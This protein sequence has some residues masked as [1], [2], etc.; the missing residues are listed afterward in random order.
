[1]K[2]QKS[3]IAGF[4]MLILFGLPV[5][6]ISQQSAPEKW[7]L[8]DTRQSTKATTTLGLKAGLRVSNFSGSDAEGLDPRLTFALGGFL[9]YGTRL[10]AFQPEIWY[11]QNGASMDMG[12]YTA[13]I[14][15]SYLNIPLLFKFRNPLADMMG[16]TDKGERM[17][18]LGPVIGLKLSSAL[19]AES[20]GS[21]VSVNLRNAKSSSLGLAVGGDANWPIGKTNR[22]YI[23]ARFN[24]G[25]S[26]PFNNAKPGGGVLVNPYT[27]EALNLKH[28]ALDLMVG[29]SF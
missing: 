13:I 29:L 16:N 9:K 12:G 25:L 11:A 17:L 22:F 18:Y 3:I 27:G 21:A 1:M 5:I 23:D 15:F 24:I 28:S 4:A 20:G 8:G 26:N 6:A 2:T 10:I 14:K 7:N 19:V